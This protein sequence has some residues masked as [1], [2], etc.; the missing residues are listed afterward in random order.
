MEYKIAYH[1]DV[2]ILLREMDN[3]QAKKSTI[4]CQIAIGSVKN[5]EEQG[6]IRAGRTTLDRIIL[7][8]GLSK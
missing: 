7:R 1:F 3:T 6:D 2:Y 8:E 5:N 4:Q